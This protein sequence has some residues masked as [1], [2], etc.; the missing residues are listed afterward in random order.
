MY[1]ICVEKLVQTGMALQ[2][3][4]MDFAALAVPHAPLDGARRD[5]LINQLTRLKENCG[6][7]GL[8]STHDL[9][10]WVV[11]DYTVRPHTLGELKSTVESI[12]VVFRQELARHFFAHIDLEK[13]KYMKSWEVFVSDPPYGHGAA[14]AFPSSRRDM[15]H[16][17]CCFACGFDDACVYHL[18]RVLEK[19]LGALAAVF[20]EPFKYEN[21]HNVIERLESRIRKIDSSL[22]PDWKTQQQF[23]SEVA[24]AFMFLKDAWRNHVMHG[25]EDFDSVRAK[26][27]YDHVCVFMRQ[28]AE[29]GLAEPS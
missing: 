29:G 17:G 21:W 8:V 19:G 9:V 3:M 6:D 23:Y 12:T 7:Y 22:G 4:Q 2:G 15:L 1:Q 13:A 20:S 10:A 26:N 27:I 18:M 16:A 28:L 24:C 5:R 11:N 25:R 14:G